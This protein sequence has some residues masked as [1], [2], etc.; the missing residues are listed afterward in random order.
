MVVTLASILFLICYFI[1]KRLRA[2]ETSP[3]KIKDNKSEPKIDFQ[4]GSDEE[5]LSA[6]HNAKVPEALK[7]II[8]LQKL[9]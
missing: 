9:D 8:V 5:N 1:V 7:K 2:K 4:T 3:P 6:F